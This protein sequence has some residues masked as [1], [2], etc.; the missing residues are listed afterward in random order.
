M[1][2]L[3]F[4]ADM[5]F[6]C[7]QQ[8][9]SEEE[10]AFVS[11]SITFCKLEEAWTKHSKAV[12]GLDITCHVVFLGFRLL[13]EKFFCYCLVFHRFCFALQERKR[14]QTQVLNYLCQS[15]SRL[16]RLVWKV[17]MDFGRDFGWW[18]QQQQRRIVWTQ[19]CSHKSTWKVGQQYD[20]RSNNLLR[21]YIHIYRDE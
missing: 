20:K 9:K 8:Q 13:S 18:Q 19:M 3:Q 2:C 1:Q 12:V 4:R 15:I 11:R 10:E 21:P 16:A 17:S 5:N 14:G 6:R 7:L